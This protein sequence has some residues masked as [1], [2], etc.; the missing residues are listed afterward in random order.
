MDNS[1]SPALVKLAN[2]I[3]RHRRKA[4]LTQVELAD[5]I[6]CSDKT[7]SAIETYRDRPSR[8]MVIAIEKA[9]HL[10]EGALVDLYDLL[11]GESLPGWMRDWIVEERSASRLRS[12][13]LATIPGLLR[14]RTTPE[15][16]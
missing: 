12:F 2:A 11:E 4:G 14:P 8:Q 6:P 1:R 16:C 5:L 10:S 7:I 9:L 15:R 13:N 3:K